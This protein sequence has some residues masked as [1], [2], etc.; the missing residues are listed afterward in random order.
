MTPGHDH[1]HDGE[2]I[3]DFAVVG[4]LASIDLLTR[5]NFTNGTA[6]SLVL[7]AGVAGG[8][9][10]GYLLTQKFEIDPGAAHATTLGL[11][12][13]IAN[14]ALLVEPTGA[15]HGDS[16]M[17]LLLAGSAIGAGG[18]FAYGQVANLTSGQATFVSTLTLLGSATAAF[19]AIT[20][21]QDGKYGAF[22]N[23]TLAIGL[24]GGTVV[25]CVI[26]PH[27]DW[28]PHRSKI[29]MAY[30]MLGAVVGGMAAGLLDDP[31][32]TNNDRSGDLITASMT[33]GLWGGFALGIVV[34]RDQAPDPVFGVP[35]P[36]KKLATSKVTE[37][38]G[39]LMPWIG[40]ERTLGVMAGGIF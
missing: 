36:G 32:N 2:V 22:E 9:G 5:H 25:G 7:L 13:G 34:T 24:D 35:A 10:A 11:L 6:D 21:S 3:T 1:L 38:D 26:A 23:T 17:A 29:V 19:T 16:V 15:N 18:G 31:G 4:S 14:G 20:G 30:T 40:R 33:A 39:T 27:L 12:V 28:S 37:R 8:G